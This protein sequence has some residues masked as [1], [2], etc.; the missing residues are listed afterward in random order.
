MNK[1]Y[2][3]ILERPLVFFDLETTG[4]NIQ[5]DRIVEICFAK[6]SPG[7]ELEVTTKLIN[8]GVHIPEESS[9]IHGITD[10]KVKDAHSFARE[11]PALLLY[12]ENSDLAGYNIKRFD[13]PLLI[14]EFKRAG[15]EFNPLDKN[16]ID[17]QTIFHKKEPRTLSAAY[18][19]FC[20]KDL[21]DAHSAEAD[22]L[23]SIEVLIGELDRYSD[24]PR[25]I[26]S[27]SKFCDQRDPTWIDSTGKFR[28]RDG[29]PIVA[30]SKHSGT[31]IE[32]LVKNEPGFFRW[33]QRQSF[34][35]DAKQIAADALNGKFP[36]KKI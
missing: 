26:K 34:T 1:K 2:N 11:A 28:W 20:N 25:D 31:T 36:K 17:M 14:E 7:G 3:F 35:Q 16:I 4:I 6:L 30:F 13:I 12:L 23:A 22:V 18:K 10:E 24:L 32:D 33:M 29:K 19:T 15:Y 21:V 27:L 9:Q 8:P 5:K